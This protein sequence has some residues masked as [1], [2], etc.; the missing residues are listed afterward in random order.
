MGWQKWDDNELGMMEAVV[1]KMS[2]I[3]AHV[4]SGEKGS[5]VLH[6]LQVSASSHLIALFCMHDTYETCCN[7]SHCN[8]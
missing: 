2:R 6:K 1:T 4:S 3:I 8:A 7:Q 5:H